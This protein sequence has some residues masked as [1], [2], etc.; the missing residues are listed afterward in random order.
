MLEYGCSPTLWQRT[1]KLLS[2]LI[3]AS[4]MLTAVCTIL[5]ISDAVSMVGE[6]E[7]MPKTLVSLE[8]TSLALFV[9]M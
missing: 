4:A 7:E 5:S 8:T 3:V 2:L 9:F 1:A 6:T